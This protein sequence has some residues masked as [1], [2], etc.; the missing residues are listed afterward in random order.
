MSG[1]MTFPD[2]SL[3]TSLLPVNKVYVTPSR[4]KKY[5]TPFVFSVFIYLA[6]AIIFDIAM[7]VFSLNYMQHLYTIC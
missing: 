2:S 4:V 6:I 3:V 7:K 1:R 5:P